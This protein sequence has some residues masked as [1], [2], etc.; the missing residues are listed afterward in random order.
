MILHTKSPSLLTLLL[1]ALLVLAGCS[2]RLIVDT[3]DVSGPSEPTSFT[4]NLKLSGVMG[5]ADASDP[6]NTV[7]EFN[8]YVYKPHST[9]ADDYELEV[10]KSIPFNTLI[11]SVDG[12]YKVYMDVGST[13]EKAVLVGVNLT[14]E[15]KAFI[16]VKTL[17]ALCSTPILDDVSFSS[18]APSTGGLPM[19]SPRYTTVTLVGRDDA[20]FAL[21]NKVTVSLHRLTSKIGVGLGKKIADGVISGAQG[22]LSN[23]GWTLDY[24]NKGSFLCYGTAASDAV[25]YNMDGTKA[26][27]AEFTAIADFANYASWLPIAG[28]VVNFDDFTIG[29]ASE[30]MTTSLPADADEQTRRNARVGLTRIVVSGLFTPTMGWVEEVITDTGDPDYDQDNPDKKN[31]VQ[32]PGIFA[33]GEGYLYLN[34][35]HLA[36]WDP[37]FKIGTDPELIK[38]FI[39]KYTGLQDGDALIEDIYNYALK[40]YT[41]G[42]NYWLAFIDDSEGDIRR[43]N[44]YRVGIESIRVPG[45]NTGKYDPVPITPPELPAIPGDITVNTT[46]V[47]WES[48]D[49]DS[50]LNP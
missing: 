36:D 3:G 1:S 23:L 43:N 39:V 22:V 45:S 27:P 50:G 30:N 34:Y 40:E 44:F 11:P 42:R 14:S 7:E 25:D 12:S 29:Y 8:I 18:L 32:K 28:D 16:G 13:G 24:M 35:A 5:T 15:L 6:E 21:Q 20:N 49:I 48:V 4:I 41:G 2:E 10:S 19:F 31:L 46:V 17:N 33:E 37:F 47:P 9:V 38:R 26:E